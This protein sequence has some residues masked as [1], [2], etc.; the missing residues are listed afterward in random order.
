M[1]DKN[2]VWQPNAPTTPAAY[3]P[4]NPYDGAPIPPP[5][6]TP[7]RPPWWLLAVILVIALLL[8]AATGLVYETHA[9]LSR[10][11]GVTPTVPPTP[12][13]TPT[14]TPIPP[15]ATPM[16]IV[17][18]PTPQ[19]QAT[20]QDAIVPYTASQIFNDFQAA[21]IA[22]ANV[23]TDGSWC[24]Q[25]DYVPSGGAVAWDDWGGSSAI[26]TEIATFATTHALLD[27]VKTL[28]SDGFSVKYQGRCLLFY[29]ASTLPDIDAYTRVMRQYCY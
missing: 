2:T 3:N 28:Q 18:T 14:P 20:T 5:P 8:F 12:T 4:Y 16:V 10:Q 22:M 27:D 15:T 17:A 7:K 13:S 19:P 26:N 21:G 24:H 29:G 9:L 11:V 6:P 1:D 23:H 25:C